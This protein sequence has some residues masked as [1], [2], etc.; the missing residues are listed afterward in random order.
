MPDPVAPVR[1]RTLWGI[2]TPRTLRVHWML[3]EL[4]LDYACRAIGSRT[5]E[6]R[7]PEYLALD[8]RGKIP[9]LVEDDFVLAESGAITSYLADR[10]AP[11]RFQPAAGSRDRGLHD[12]WVHFV[13]MELDATALYVVRRHAGLPE[14]YGEAPAAVASSIGYFERQ[15]SVA[16]KR[17][18]DGRPCLL[19]EHL[20]VADLLLTTCLEWAR[21][22]KAPVPAPLDDYV[23]RIRTRPAY[24]AAMA[25]NLPPEALAAT[26]AAT[27]TGD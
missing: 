13:L 9:L 17:L 2:G 21:F 16:A 12:Q 20:Q 10:Y 1:K 14:I 4:D 6:T 27:P 5:G 18:A 24:E 26:A 11:G 8:P 25:A 7:T 23:A 3:A 19:G 22:V 15:V